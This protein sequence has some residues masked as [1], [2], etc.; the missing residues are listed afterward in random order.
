MYFRVEY[1]T[2]TL[3]AVG[4]RPGTTEI[5]EGMN[6]LMK[7]YNKYLHTYTESI[8][9]VQ[10]RIQNCRDQQSPVGQRARSHEAHT[11]GGVESS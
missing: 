7:C 2:S 3:E 8:C 10:G 9:E 1:L 6:E 11:S 5:D 4:S